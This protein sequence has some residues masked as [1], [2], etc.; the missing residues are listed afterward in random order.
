MVYLI[1]LLIRQCISIIIYS[2]CVTF[3]HDTQA[4]SLR[5]IFPWNL[6]SRSSLQDE[7]SRRKGIVGRLFPF[8]AIDI[9]KGRKIMGVS[10]REK[11]TWSIFPLRAG[12]G[13]GFPKKGKRGM[14][15]ACARLVARTH[16]RTPTRMR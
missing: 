11:K 5:P 7:R 13:T 1:S 16:A 12:R 15:V 8:R 6:H 3:Q 9:R 4:R 10:Q 14:Q 2:M